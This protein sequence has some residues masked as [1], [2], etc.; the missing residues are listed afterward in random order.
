[1]KKLMIAAAIVCAAAL[2]QAASVTW[3]SGD[4]TALPS[5]YGQ[6][7]YDITGSGEVSGCIQ[8]YVWE[9]LTAF[10]YTTAAEVYNAYKA[11]DL[12]IANAKTATSDAFEGFAN[13]VGANTFTEGQNVYAAILYLHNH[14][15]GQEITGPVDFYMAN[16]ASAKAADAGANV[17]SLGNTF[18]GVGG[19]SA[20]GGA[21]EWAAVPE[22][23]SG[24]L[25]LLG[26]AGLALRRRRA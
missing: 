25:L 10:D 1:M 22:P 7:E 11:G 2:S 14:E 3:S 4:F 12:D 13:V 16:L 19:T 21:T 15:D 17:A 6:S 20:S 5:C 9:S 24:L 18:G 23:T 8:A 26:V